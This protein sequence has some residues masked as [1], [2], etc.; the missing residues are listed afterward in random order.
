M[1]ETI[2]LSQTEVFA[3]RNPTPGT[4]L[5]VQEAREAAA[6]LGQLHSLLR[7]LQ[8]SGYALVERNGALTLA[9]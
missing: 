2:G 1:F 8:A 4:D 6:K 5:A 7:S 9:V 3:A